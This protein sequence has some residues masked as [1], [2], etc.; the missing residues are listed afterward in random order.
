[1]WFDQGRADVR[2]EWGSDGL[3]ALLPASDVVVIVDVLSFSTCVDVAVS[4]GAA[5]IPFASRGEVAAA[6]AA[7]AGA[8]CAGP[9][10]QARFSLS[11]ASFMSVEPGTRV[12]LPSPNGGALA[13]ET[14]GVPTFTACLRNAPA[15]A[16]AAARLGRRIA[17][18]EAG[19]EEDVRVAA[20]YDVSPC[21]P[22]LRT[23]AFER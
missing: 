22:V 2:A 7:G 15:V 23:G 14:A 1:V 5:V 8:A 16:R 9:R 20:E 21:A 19:F 3:S 12:V 11:P 13:A 17:L 10:G 18:I 6:F 4:R